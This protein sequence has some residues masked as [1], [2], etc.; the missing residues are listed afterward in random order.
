MTTS[1]KD[2]IEEN[3]DLIETNLSV[4]FQKVKDDLPFIDHKEIIEILEKC[5]VHTLDA[6]LENIR[7]ELMLETGVIYRNIY[8]DTFIDRYFSGMLGFDDEFIKKFIIQEKDNIN[9]SLTQDDSGE[10][11]LTSE[12]GS[13]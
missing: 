12:I 9:C 3:V 4:F 7:Y 1:V 5:G 8:L 11:I 10:W 13:M 6:R 2:F